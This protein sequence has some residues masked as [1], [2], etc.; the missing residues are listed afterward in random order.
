MRFRSIRSKIALAAAGLSSA[1]VIIFAVVS[2]FWFYHEQLD[3][4]SDDGA[5]QPSPEQFAEAWDE[6]LEL[7]GAYLAAL[8]VI[9]IL[10]A[11]GAWWLA[12]RV[13]D[14][15]T[16]LAEQ[17]E[18]TDARSLSERLPEPRG[19]DEIARLARVLNHLLSRL[20][21][22]FAQAGRFAADASH[23]LR[24]PL[25]IMRGTIEEAIQAAPGSPQ[26]PGLVSLLEENQRLVAI[27]EKLLLLARADAGQLSADFQDVD[28]SAMIEDIAVDFTVIAEERGLRI[29]SNVASAVGVEADVSL[30]RHLFL[31]LFDN[32]VR[33]NHPGGWIRCS[34]TKDDD[35][36]IFE[37]DNSGPPIAEAAR[38]RL[39]ER[40]FRPEAA[41]DRVT[42]GA[43]LGLSLCSEIASAH[44]G[45][46]TFVGSDV[47]GTTF[48]F[49]MPVDR[50]P[51]PNSAWGK[52]LSKSTR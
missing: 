25:A 47:G 4:M 2:G 39:F 23:E 38:T 20:G 41:R 29:E 28:L 42:G 8:P 26:A 18:R 31:N 37:I 30:V 15:I 13:A 35:R 40:F 3:A 11:I 6:L 27:T 51:R 46:L 7:S 16:M 5:N 19:D 49:E 9:A 10:A 50:A 48:R 22:S 12:G 52:L 32:A 1:I 21:E 34:L 43:G 24:T 14:P 45:S 44:F 36:A 33:H 17:A